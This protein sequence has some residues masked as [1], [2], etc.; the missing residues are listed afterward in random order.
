MQTLVQ[1]IV[2]GDGDGEPLA[3]HSIVGEVEGQE[4]WLE[5]GDGGDGGQAK[6]S[7]VT[8]AQG[9]AHPLCDGVWNGV[10]DIHCATLPANKGIHASLIFCQQGHTNLINIL[11]T[12]CTFH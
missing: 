1:V 12:T 9:V 3:P 10:G 4:E 5:S 11:P 7:A 8:D 2:D 6:A